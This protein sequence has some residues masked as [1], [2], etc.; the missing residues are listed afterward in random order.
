M[1]A[2]DMDAVTVHPLC[3]ATL[4]THHALRSLVDALWMSVTRDVT[5][6]TVTVHDIVMSLSMHCHCACT[7]TVVVLSLW[8]GCHRGCVTVDVLTGALWMR[9]QP[10]TWMR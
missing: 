5:G 3:G 1:H 6:C 8:M 2:M 10:V 4:S 7:V 9:C